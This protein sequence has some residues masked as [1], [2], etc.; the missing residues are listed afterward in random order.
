MNNL[1]RTRRDAMLAA[2]E[3]HFGDSASWSR[4]EGG[5]FNWLN[6]PEGVDAGELL[7]RATEA[8]VTYCKGTDFYPDGRGASSLRLAYSFPSPDE[9]ERGVAILAELAGEMKNNA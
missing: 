1:L 3:R 6:L 9:I 8:G 2:L 7:A 4:P 5:Y